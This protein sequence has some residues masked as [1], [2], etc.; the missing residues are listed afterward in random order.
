MLKTFSEQTKQ[1]V[2]AMIDRPIDQLLSNQEIRK[3]ESVVNTGMMNAGLVLSQLV[4]S[5]V[6]LFMPE[7][8]LTDKDKLTEEVRDPYEH[9]FGLKIRMSGDLNGN[10]LMIFSEEKGK[11]LSNKLLK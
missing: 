1:R 7:I 8:S 10:L 9:F 5:N 3:L 6:E 2:E 11:E 4:G